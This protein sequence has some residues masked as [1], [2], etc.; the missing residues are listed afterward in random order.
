M[1]I[2]YFL[3]LFAVFIMSG[4]SNAAEP[5]NKV[6]EV[7]FSVKAATD[8]EKAFK[9]K[10]VPWASIKNSESDSVRLIDSSLK[11]ISEREATVIIDY[12]VRAPVSFNITSE[13]GFTKSDLLR[14]IG[15]IYKQMYIDEEASSTIKTVP[16]NQRQGVINRNTTDGKYGIW[17]HDIDDLV[18]SSATI[19]CN[20]GKCVIELG[21]ES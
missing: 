13:N 16:M 15:Q 20:N 14:K 2:R 7:T 4:C 21:I 8:Q 6:Y 18:L 12:P 11:V 10:I 19:S 17:G 1:H 9:D 3:V 5:K